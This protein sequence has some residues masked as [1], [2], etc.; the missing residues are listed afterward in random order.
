MSPASKFEN[1]T[2]GF[3]RAPRE[4][5]EKIMEKAA[6]PGEIIYVNVDKKRITVGLG[7]PPDDQDWYATTGQTRAAA[8]REKLVDEG[9]TVVEVGP[10]DPKTGKSSVTVHKKDESTHRTIV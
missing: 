9:Y 3:D 7:E 10:E 5:R 4:E 6:G 1:P 8:N 2:G